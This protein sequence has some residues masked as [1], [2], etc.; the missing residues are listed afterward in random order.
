MPGIM[1]GIHRNLPNDWE[2]LYLGHYHEKVE[3][4]I[5]LKNNFSANKLHT[6]D[7][8]TDLEIA[9]LVLAKNLNAYAVHP[10]IIIQ[11]KGQDG[12][13]NTYPGFID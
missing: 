12:L 10:Q 6:A 4:T 8:A 7:V 2:L 11:W 9:S 13:S 5:I 1:P 3:E